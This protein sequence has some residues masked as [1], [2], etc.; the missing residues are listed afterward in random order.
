MI[1]VWKSKTL[2]CAKA[3]RLST[4]PAESKL[5]VKL[6]DFAKKVSSP[7]FASTAI[8]M[9]SV[10][11]QYVQL[12][13]SLPPTLQRFF[14]RFPPQAIRSTPI[15]LPSTTPTPQDDLTLGTSD[16]ATEVNPNS[17]VGNPFFPQKHPVTGRR[18]DPVYSLRRQAD[19]IKLAKEHGVAELLPFSH[20]SLEERTRKREE[21]GLRVKGTGVGQRV[22]GHY[23]ERTTKQRLEKR[24]QAMLQMPEMIN[25]WKMVSGCRSLIFQFH[26]LIRILS[27]VTAVSGLNGHVKCVIL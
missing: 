3:P 26:M 7:F 12:A 8:K 20:R 5:Q 4:L 23:H 11:H 14:A 13:K 22:K 2:R 9:A 19:L 27:S 17:R 25:R 1:H 6:H 15:A 24:R 18:H 21:Q 10:N 16:I